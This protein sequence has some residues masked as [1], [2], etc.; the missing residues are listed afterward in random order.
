[1]AEHTVGTAEEWRAAREALLAEEKELTRRG[2][3]LARKR[4]ELPWVPV[5]KD[6]AFETDGGTRSLADL[7]D[8]RSQLLV[9]HFMFGP[10]YE[11]GCPVCSSIADNLD[12]NAVHLAARDAKLMLVSRASQEK[13]Q[14]YKRRM[15]WSLDWAST[16][17][18]DF[19]R[20]LGFLHTREEL[21]PFLDGELPPAVV[22]NAQACGVDAGT[23]VAEGP[24]LSVYARSNG[25]VYRT[26]VSTARG[27]EPAMGYYFLLDR[28]PLGRNEEGEEVFWLRRRDE[29]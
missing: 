16:V 28:A 26:Y 22:Q 20:D 17:G 3:A 5:E 2:D 13:L 25:T 8:G 29:Y 9:Y 10:D 12:P 23:Y 11:A 27:L 19:N 4:R 7:F 1:M 24:G 15:G 6:Y 18:G 21:Q 14:E